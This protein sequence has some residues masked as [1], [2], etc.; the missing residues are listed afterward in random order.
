MAEVN[1]AAVLIANLMAMTMLFIILINRHWRLDRRVRESDALYALVVLSFI[2]CVIDCVSNLVAGRPGVLCC[3][4]GYATNTW[5]YAMNVVFGPLW[6][7]CPFAFARRPGISLAAYGSL[8]S[9]TARGL[10]RRRIAAR[11]C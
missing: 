2:S 8:D 5:L 6:V 10:S 11:S 3:V 9:P 7:Y 1:I 4:V